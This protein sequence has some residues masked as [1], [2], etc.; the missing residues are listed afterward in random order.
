MPVRRP[1]PVV[2]VGRR[3]GKAGIVG[4]QPLPQSPPELRLGGRVTEVHAASYAPVLEHPL[5]AGPGVAQKV[6][7][8]EGTT[9][10]DV[11]Q[12]V[13][14]VPDASVH[15][16]RRLAHLTPGPGAV[17]LGHGGRGQS[18]GRVE[19]V[20]GPGGMT[21]HAPGSLGLHPGV[22]QQMLD[23][24]E[25]PDRGTVLVALCRIGSGQ[26]DRPA[27]GPHQVGAGQRHTEGRPPGQVVRRERPLP[28]DGHQPRHRSHPGRGAG[29]VDA[30][31]GHGQVGPRQAATVGSG[32]EDQCVG[33][34]LHVDGH[35]R[36]QLALYDGQRRKV[37][38]QHDGFDAVTGGS[39][40]QS[41]ELASQGRPEEGDVGQT[42]AQFLGHD[43]G[44][45]PR[46]QGLALVVARPQL[47]PAGGGH[48]G[49]ELRRPL[50]VIDGADGVGPEP[51]DQSG[52]GL[53][54]GPVVP[55]KG[56]RPSVDRRRRKERRRPFVAQHAAQHL[57]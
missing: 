46:G 38:G 51:I 19:G 22:G 11:G 40:G 25:R 53:G 33:G 6:A 52:G 29:Q 48:S 3:D 4:R 7:G 47:P 49:I 12:A 31:T 27:H 43:A 17:G 57:A 54:A 23:G 30:R 20:H 16:D 39:T 42:P 36:H 32:N 21:G 13:P 1:R 45:H 9:Q 35:A 34:A 10:V 5:Q 44:F 14:C 56:G 28:V 8:E 15:L 41:S 26:P 18:L 37:G 24:L 55:A 50:A 2:V